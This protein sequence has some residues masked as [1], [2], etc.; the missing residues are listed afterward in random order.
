MNIPQAPLFRDPIHDGAADPTIIYNREEK[1]WWLLYTNRPTKMSDIGVNW[2]HGSDIGIAESTDN[3]KRWL[4]RGTLCGLDYERGRNTY[5]APE[6]IYHDGTY[7][8][9]ISYVRGVPN[10]WKWNRNILHYTSKNLWDWEF[11]SKLPLSSDKVIDAAVFRMSNGKW[12][13]WYKDEA[14]GSH[15]W[16][17]DSAD[18]Y[19]WEVV[20]EVIGD[21][22]HEGVNVFEFGGYYWLITDEWHGLGVYRSD[23]LENWTKQSECILAQG[24]TREDDGVMGGHADIEVNDGKAY[25]FYFTHPERTKENM[26]NNTGDLKRSSIQVAELKAENGVLTCD[27][28]ADFDFELKNL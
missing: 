14:H 11:Q 24:G 8:M 7:H 9:Y 20:G 19:N 2:V 4:Y 23:D 1:S 6:V 22:P 18:L 5:W 25:I 12:R 15:T 10:D 17:A 21:V 16:A 28:N 26:E 13:M 27:R 3:G